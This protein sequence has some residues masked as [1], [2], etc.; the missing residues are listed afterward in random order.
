LVQLCGKQL[1]YYASAKSASMIAA[2]GK[3]AKEPPAEK[4]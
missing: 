1:E 3:P 2:L 4:A